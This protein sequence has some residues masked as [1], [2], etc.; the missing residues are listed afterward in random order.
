MDVSR[1]NSFIEEVN[2]NI[3]SNYLPIADIFN[4]QYDSPELDP[5]RVEVCECLICG[6]NLAAI[7]LTNHL[8]EAS[9]KTCLTWKHSLDNKDNNLGF[10]DVFKV[11]EYD[12]MDMQATINKACTLGLISKEQKKLLNKFRDMYRNA[13]SHASA[14][15]TFGNDTFKANAVSLEN[16]DSEDALLEQ[17]FAEPSMDIAV[18]DFLPVHGIAKMERAKEESALY[19]IEVDSVIRDMLANIRSK[20]KKAESPKAPCL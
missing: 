4:T 10:K 5:I 9:L 15:K 2:S 1:V 19:F 8:L 12:N 14:S 16:G 3:T 7:T 13:Y 6:L 18:K 20:Y 17:I 11:P